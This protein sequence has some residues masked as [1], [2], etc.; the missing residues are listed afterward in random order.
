MSTSLKAR[1]YAAALV[2]AGLLALLAS[3]SPAVLRWYDQQLPQGATFPAMVVQQISN[4]RTYVT[5]GRMPTGFSRM[6][7]RIFGTGNDSQNASAVVAAL[8]NFL[9]GFN[10]SGIAGLAQYSNII[11]ADRDAGLA[12]T[13]PLTFQRIVD[14]MIFSNDNL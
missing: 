8:A 2:D 3:G 13:Q 10:G 6:Q 11:V 4:P 5:T 9:D 7:F 14:A 12:N 1:L